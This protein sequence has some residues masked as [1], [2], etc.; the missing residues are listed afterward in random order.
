MVNDQL[1]ELFPTIDVER[2]PIELLSLM[3]TI[4]A[5][6]GSVLSASAGNINKHQLFNPVDSGVMLVVTTMIVSAGVS[7]NAE[8]QISTAPLTNDAGNVIR[9]DTRFGVAALVVGQNRFVQ[10]AAGLAP[11]VVFRLIIDT[12]FT[13]GDQNGLFVL[14]PGTGVTFASTSSNVS[15]S[16]QFFW[17]ERVFEPAE[18]NF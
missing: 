14:F 2:V 4:V 15:T 18:G 3:G 5:A 1:N 6:G 10:S 12:P 11:H 8:L 7:G 17:R 16:C 9:R 13:F